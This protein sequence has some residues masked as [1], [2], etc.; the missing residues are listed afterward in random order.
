MGSFGNSP[1]LRRLADLK[2][3]ELKAAL[4]ELCAVQVLLF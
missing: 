2:L 4:A 3:D 1:K